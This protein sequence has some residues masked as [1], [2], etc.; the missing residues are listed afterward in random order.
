MPIPHRQFIRKA[1]QRLKDKQGQKRIEEIRKLQQELPCYFTGHYGKVRKWL[2]SEL[3]KT[4]TSQKV[5]HKD[6]FAVKKEG[7]V[8][9]AIVGAPNI[10][11]SSL[12]KALTNV[13]AKVADYAFTTLK[14]I[15]AILN[16]NGAQIQLIEVPGLIEGTAKGKGSG[17]AFLSVARNADFIILMHDLSKG[18]EELKMILKELSSYKIKKPSLIIGN[19]ADLP[20]APENLKEIKATFQEY[21]IVPISI[22]EGG[23]LQKVKKEVWNFLKLTRIFPKDKNGKA[24]SSPVILKQGDNIECFVEKIHK[25]LLKDFKFAKVWGKSTKFAGQK[26]GLTHILKDKDTVQI[27]SK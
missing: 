27:V 22:K 3:K 8:Q 24:A 5:T 26:V 20:E 14:P 12:L 19:K 18:K 2:V 25:D 10:G 17:R 11:K 6:W 7:V 16:L 1:K 9:I 23:G 15:P 21:K 13:Q 4:Q